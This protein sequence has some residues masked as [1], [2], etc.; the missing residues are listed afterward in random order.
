MVSLSVVMNNELS[1]GG[2]QRIRKL[3]S[4]HFFDHFRN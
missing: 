4:R 2:P 3:S 1:N